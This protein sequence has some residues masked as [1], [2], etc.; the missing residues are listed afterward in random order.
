MPYLATAASEEDES[1]FAHVGRRAGNG[2]GRAYHRGVKLAGC[3]G[4]CILDSVFE[5]PFCN[6]WFILRSD[7]SG[8]FG[9]AGWLTSVLTV[10][11]IGHFSN[12]IESKCLPSCKIATVSK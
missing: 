8:G 2:I 10:A 7:M 5:R 4:R 12:G 11:M 9:V 1:Q 6:F 3:M